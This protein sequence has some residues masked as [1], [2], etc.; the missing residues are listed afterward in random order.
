MKYKIVIYGIGEQYNKNFNTIKYFE[1]LEQF[2][3]VGVTAK[4][5]PDS[6]S[7]DGYNIISVC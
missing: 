6:T 5:M 2:S 3:V 1:L 7:L 4:W